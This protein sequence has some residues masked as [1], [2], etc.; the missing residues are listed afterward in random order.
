MEYRPLGRTGMEVSPLCLGTMM[1]GAWGDT[2]AADCERIVHS[3][4]D[5][6]INFVDTADVYA[7]GESEELLGRALKGR[8]DDVVLAT[9]VGNPMADEPNRRGNSRRWI[10]RSVEDSLRRL[11][12]DW[13]DLYQ[14]HRP[15]P[16]TDLD[17]SLGALS[18]LV[19]QG[20]VRAV[21][22]S[23]YPAAELVRAAW[24]ADARGRERF[25]TEQPPYSIFARGIERDVLPVC[26]EL[27]LAAIVWAP[28]NRGWLSGKYRRGVPAMSD[29]RA[30]R[31]RDHFDFGS[32][33][34]EHKLDAIDALRP[35]ADEVGCSL[36]HFAL[37]F[38]L[39]HPAVTSTII[40]P[41]T[42][43]QLESMLGAERVVIHDD[44]LD[45]IDEIVPPG[46]TINPVDAGY[47][48]PSI[49]DSRLRRRVR[50]FVAGGAQVKGR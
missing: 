3:A 36:I 20:K 13:I 45:H 22:T 44:V 1:F 34:A 24:L 41:R 19:R 31:Q 10:V 43:E 15:D 39:V 9:K 6:G 18:E 14:L 37:A 4:L 21:G 5:H 16:T 35:L 23:T 49:A 26:Q 29:S 28:L 42:I 2:S 7:R 25:A 40:G 27:G 50:A 30:V 12:T 38:T 17:E 48:P 8:R 32:V 11:G 33:E 47:V 46:T